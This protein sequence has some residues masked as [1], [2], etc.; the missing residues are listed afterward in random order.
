MK[1]F[2]YVHTWASFRTQ[3]NNLLHYWGFSFCW[4][5]QSQRKF[6][7]NSL[8]VKVFQDISVYGEIAICLKI[9]RQFSVYFQNVLLG[10]IIYFGFVQNIF[11]VLYAFTLLNHLGLQW[12][13]LC[14]LCT[15]FVCMS[16][17]HNPLSSSKLSL[18]VLPNLECQPQH[19]ISLSSW[20]IYNRDAIEGRTLEIFIHL[21]S[22]G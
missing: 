14:F 22:Y 13:N 1:P 15:Q 10:R 7:L 4:Y 5:L 17:S 20:R 11:H 9:S 16:L 18:G 8:Q 19:P 6:G 12:P 3:E 21:G 2:C